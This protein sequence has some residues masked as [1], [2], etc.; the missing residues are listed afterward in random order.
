MYRNFNYM[1][2]IYNR[3]NPPVPPPASKPNTPQP[4]AN[5]KPPQKKK[6]PPKKKL[7]FKTLKKDTCTSLN[8][9]EHFLNDCSLFLKYVK[10][11]KLLK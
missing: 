2:P 1:N 4:P 11:Y 3:S 10:L 5:C 6:T 7:N 9:V 8:D